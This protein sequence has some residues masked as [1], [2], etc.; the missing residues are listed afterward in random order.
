MNWNGRGGK[1]SQP[2]WTTTATFAWRDRAKPMK[3]CQASWCHGQDSHQALPSEPVPSVYLYNLS[4]TVT[5]TSALF[6]SQSTSVCPYPSSYHNS[7]PVHT[8][9]ASKC[10]HTH[11]SIYLHSPSSSTVDFCWCKC[12]VKSLMI[13]LILQWRL[14]VTTLLLAVLSILK[15]LYTIGQ[16]SSYHP[17]TICVISPL[18]STIP[19]ECDFWGQL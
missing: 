10:H 14:K 16:S 17:A 6:I 11:S 18:S 3:I 5:R 4:I 8:L 1:W 9:H 7:P 19:K 2:I 13:S 15:C 12:S